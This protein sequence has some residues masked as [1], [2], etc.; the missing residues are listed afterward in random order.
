MASNGEEVILRSRTASY[1]IMPTNHDASAPMSQSE[2]EEK[3]LGALKQVENH[4]SGV[5]KML[6]WE[7]L[8][9]EL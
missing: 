8:R 5:K 2:F 3:L 6:S 9:S 1:R 7:E 4:L